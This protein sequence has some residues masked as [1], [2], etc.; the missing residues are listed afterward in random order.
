MQLFANT[1]TACV[2]SVHHTP[3]PPRTHDSKRRT[4]LVVLGVAVDA[5]RH[6]PLGQA[7]PRPAPRSPR[8]PE[9]LRGTKKIYG[10]VLNR[11]RV[12]ICS[13]SR[14]AEP[15]AAAPSTCCWAARELAGCKLA[16]A[17]ARAVRQRS[18]KI[19]QH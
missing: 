16:R 8:R 17:D 4:R 15:R 5:R 1:Y 12:R 14:A 13:L 9:H 6:Q 2:H 18:C 19:V 11:F 7:P 10:R 3:L